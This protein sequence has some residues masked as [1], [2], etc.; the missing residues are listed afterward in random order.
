MSIISAGTSNTTTLVYTGD[1]TGNLVFQSNGTTEAMR[2]TAAGNVGIGT[3]S[4]S[5]PLQVSG[6]ITATSINTNNTFGFKN[7]IINGAMVID[8]RNAGASVSITNSSP[9]TVDRWLGF[10]T[11]SSK[12]TVQQN[13]GSVTPPTGFTNYLGCT[14][15]SAYSV[16]ASE[17]FNIQHK[18]EGFNT[19]DLMWG[20][21][22]AKTITLSFWVRSSLTGTFGGAL[23]NGAV[24]RRYPFSYTISSADTWEQKSITI[25]GDTTGTWLT[26]NDTGINLLFSI[27]TGSSLSGTAGAW[28]ASSVNSV[29]GAVSV[30]GTSGA[31]FYITGVQLEVGSTATSF[32]YRPYGTELHLCQ[33][34]YQALSGLGWIQGQASRDTATVSYHGIIYRVPM[35]GVP[36][37]SVTDSTSNSLNRYGPGGEYYFGENA[38]SVLSL[39]SYYNNSVFVT[40]TLAGATTFESKAILLGNNATI[41][42]SAEL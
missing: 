13:A 1:T 5:T 4:P 38:A 14:S 24:D 29:T 39:S 12:F 23:R 31:T 17:T 8:Q 18:I 20:T 42:L 9:Y 11:Q 33:R 28:T 16:G 2:I 15:L 25:A 7:R 36:T 26:N 41:R 22:N 21:A 30:V 3:G 10:A 27:G 6:T 19:A 37:G 32:D 35:R 40:C 34:Y